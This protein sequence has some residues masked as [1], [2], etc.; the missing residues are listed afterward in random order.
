MTN[1][2]SRLIEKGERALRAAETLLQSGDA[3][4]AIGRAY[5]TMFHA[6]Q[7]LLRARDLRYRK[8]SGVHAAFAEHFIRP[9]VLPPQYHRWLIDAF[10]ERLNADYDAD[11]ATDALRARTSIDRAGEFLAEAKNHLKDQAGEG[12]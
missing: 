3:E 12:P 4:S 5:Y 10:D 6:A 1:E 2:A 9:G 11:F 7:A 8:H